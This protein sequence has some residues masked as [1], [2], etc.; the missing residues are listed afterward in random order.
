M[1]EAGVDDFVR[2][3]IAGWRTERAQGIYATTKRCERDAVGETLVELVHRGG[4]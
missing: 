1:R 3:S 4:C 2:R